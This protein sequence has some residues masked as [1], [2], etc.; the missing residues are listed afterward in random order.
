MSQ[1]IIGNLNQAPAQRGD[2]WNPGDTFSALEH[3]TMFLNS[4]EGVEALNLDPEQRRVLR[5]CG[6]FTVRILDV[7][8]LRRNIR[9]A[10]LDFADIATR[11]R[12]GE[13]LQNLGINNPNYEMVMTIPNGSAVNIG[14]LFEV[15]YLSILKPLEN[16]KYRLQHDY[17]VTRSGPRFEIFDN[18][19]DQ[20]IPSKAEEMARGL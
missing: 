6:S 5:S 7:F 12:H 4:V 14:M 18:D 19:P 9:L 3:H 13:A 1:L 11:D 8:K 15:G 10:E 20:Y 16:G 17:P 2:T